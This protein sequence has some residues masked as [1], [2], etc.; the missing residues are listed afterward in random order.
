MHCACQRM[1]VP[2][3]AYEGHNIIISLTKNRGARWRAERKC[4]NFDPLT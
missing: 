1:T 2:D 4:S 3:L